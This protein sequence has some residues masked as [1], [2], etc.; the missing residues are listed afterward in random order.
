MFSHL[1]NVTKFQS[2]FSMLRMVSYILNIRQMNP[3]LG[4]ESGMLYLLP[5]CLESGDACPISSE[6]S[7]SS[8]IHSLALFFFIFLDSFSSF[9]FFFDLKSVW[10]LIVLS[11]SN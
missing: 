3:S 11:H 2:I 10:S 6:P 7:L 1:K 4:K 9:F 8:T 5:K